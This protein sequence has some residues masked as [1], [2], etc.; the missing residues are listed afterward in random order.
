MLFCI[1]ACIV[2]CLTAVVQW[3]T[4][5]RPGFPLNHFINHSI[6][7]RNFQNNFLKHQIKFDINL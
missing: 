3:K 7:F 5:R 4:G 2:G 1:L 6:V